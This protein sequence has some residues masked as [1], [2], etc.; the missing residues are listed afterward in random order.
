MAFGS[1]FNLFDDDFRKFPASGVE[2]FEE[3]ISPFKARAEKAFGLENAT[4][5]DRAQVN[6]AQT[7]RTRRGR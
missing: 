2:E 7:L 3:S 4:L 6:H 1:D 5:H